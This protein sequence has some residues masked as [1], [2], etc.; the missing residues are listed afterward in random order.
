M[1][2]QLRNIALITLLIVSLTIV[3]VVSPEHHRSTTNTAIL[4]VAYVAAAGS[5]LAL[6]LGS[7]WFGVLRKDLLAWREGRPS[8][9]WTTRHYAAQ[10][11]TVELRESKAS[12]V[13]FSADVKVI[14]A[15]GL[16]CTIVAL[17]PRTLGEAE[18]RPLK[19]ATVSCA[20]ERGRRRWPRKAL[21]TRRVEVPTVKDVAWGSVGRWPDEWFDPNS[22]GPTP[23]RYRVRWEVRLPDGR[24]EKVTEKIHLAAGGEA[25]VGHLTRAASGTRAVIRHFRGLD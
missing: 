9:R 25:Y 2:R 13:F 10:E 21:Q 15:Q 20:V 3:A 24:V 4:I 17:E 11:E 7:V 19:G 12:L 6:V 5:F 22:V 23:G 14:R 18:E 1:D 16:P 8:R